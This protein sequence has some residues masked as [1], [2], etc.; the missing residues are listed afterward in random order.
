MPYWLMS[1]YS[2][3]ELNTIAKVSMQEAV[4]DL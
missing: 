1:I 4:N 3:I 2:F